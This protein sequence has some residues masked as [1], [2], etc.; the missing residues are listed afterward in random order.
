MRVTVYLV[1]LSCSVFFASAYAADAPSAPN[2]SIKLGVTSNTITI[3]QSAV[4][5]GPS[6]EL[7][8]SMREGALAYFRHVNEVEGGVYGRKI[9]LISL[10]DNGD[11]KQAL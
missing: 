7:G 5:E 1:L 8:R 6:A 2:P 9:E 4:L 11:P 3:G 10:N